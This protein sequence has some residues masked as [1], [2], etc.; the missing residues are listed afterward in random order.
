MPTRCLRR[1]PIC[2]AALGALVAVAL[3]GCL[4]P[5]PGASQIRAFDRDVFAASVQPILAE[6]CANPSCHGRPDRPM[7]L[8]SPLRW[9]MDPDRT[10]LA[11][12]LSAAELD[13]NFTMASV[14]AIGVDPEHTLILEKPLAE[15]VGMYHGGGA[16][17]EGTLD[18]GYRTI[19]A[20]LEGGW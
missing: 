6:R 9:R 5:E 19:R 17:F 13:H 20:W 2:A 12:P 3:T 18:R 11:E 15:A 16:V 4:G 10:F 8:Y 1:S 7:S 14:F